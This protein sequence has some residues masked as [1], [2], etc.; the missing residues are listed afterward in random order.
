MK[1]KSLV[2][3]SFLALLICAPMC[4]AADRVPPGKYSLSVGRVYESDPSQPKWVFILGGTGAIRGGETVCQSVAGL[5]KLLAS[6]P[7]D[8]TLDWYPT[9]R[10]ESEVLR[11]DVENLKAI[12]SKAGVTFT[13]HQ[14]G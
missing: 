6:L 9:C 7:R 10:G 11:E 8:S 12:C 2:G 5:K 1:I 14:S 13:I 4:R 3:L